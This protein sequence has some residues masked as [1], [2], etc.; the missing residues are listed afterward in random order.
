MTTILNKLRQLLRRQQTAQNRQNTM[1]QADQSNPTNGSQPILNDAALQ[2]LMQ[3]IEQTHEGMY[4]CAETFALLD[5]YVE[6]VASNEEAAKL[7]PLVEKHLAA[8][9]GCYEEYEI[10]HDIITT[11][12]TDETTP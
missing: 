2:R 4:T 11:E 5:E 8:C 6:L 10:L 9:P 12:A 7:M 3:Q 1:Q